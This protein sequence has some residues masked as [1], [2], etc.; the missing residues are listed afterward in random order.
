MGT[1]QAQAGVKPMVEYFL[2]LPRDRDVN[3]SGV[4]GDVTR[5][6]VQP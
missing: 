4:R 2:S 5:Y 1:D 6:V 3:L